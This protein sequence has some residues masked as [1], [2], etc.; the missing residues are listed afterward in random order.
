MCTVLISVTEVISLPMVFN[1]WICPSILF[2]EMLYQGN[3]NPNLKQKCIL[4]F[5]LD[6]FISEYKSKTLQ[7]LSWPWSCGS[8]IYNYLSPLMLWVRIRIKARCT[9]LCDQVCQ[10]LATGLL[11]LDPIITGQPACNVLLSGSPLG[12]KLYQNAAPP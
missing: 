2:P 3:P 1:S 5:R 6:L 4:Y 10:W 7:G 12:N 11:H 9:T 8:W